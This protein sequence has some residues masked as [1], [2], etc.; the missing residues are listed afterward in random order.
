MDQNNQ[1]E[2]ELKRKRRLANECLKRHRQKKREEAQR[3]K[4]LSQNEPNEQIKQQ[5]LQNKLERKRKLARERSKKYYYRKRL[6]SITGIRTFEQAIHDIRN[7]QIPG[8]STDMNIPIVINDYSG[9]NEPNEQ[10]NQQNKLEWQRKLARECSKR[11]RAR[12]KNKPNEQ[13]NEQIEQDKLERRRKSARERSKKYRARKRLSQITS[14]KTFEDAIHNSQIPETLTDMNVPLVIKDY[15]GKNEPSVQSNQQN[16]L[17][18]QRKLARERCKRYRDRK[19]LSNIT[20]IK[21]FEDPIHDTQIPGPLNGNPQLV[22]KNRRITIHNSQNV[23]IV[24]NVY[25]GNVHD[26]KNNCAGP[27]REG[28]LVTQANQGNY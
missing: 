20:S 4:L 11:Y 13:S 18:R 6:S 9:K 28:N 7:S 12:K 27:S 16:K 26:S 10:S 23:P 22:F 2:D 1:I 14:I 24:I 17:E 5:I 3:Q 25:M 19:R 8:T 15:S 21:A